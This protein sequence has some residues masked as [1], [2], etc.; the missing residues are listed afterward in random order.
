M[1]PPLVA[2]FANLRWGELAGLRRGDIDLEACEIRITQTL[3]Q[4]AKGGL[5]FDTKLPP[6]QG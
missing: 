1:I 2:T 4:L 5:C 3:V 6:E